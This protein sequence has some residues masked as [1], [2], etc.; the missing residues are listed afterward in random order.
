MKVHITNL[1]G[2]A[3]EAPVRR[4][5]NHLAEIGRGLGFLEMGIY[6]YP[7]DREEEEKLFTRLDGIIA[8]VEPEDVVFVQLPTGNGERFEKNLILKIKGYRDAKVVGILRDEEP[9]WMVSGCRIRNR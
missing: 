7:S 8:S 9:Y 5:Q 1:N 4:W 3:K 6:V 2:I